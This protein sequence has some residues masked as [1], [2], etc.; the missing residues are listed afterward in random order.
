[1]ATTWLDMSA[2]YGSTPDVVHALRSHK[3]GRLLTQEAQERGTSGKSSYLPCNH[4]NVS[5]CTWPGVDTL[6]L[7]AGGDPRTNEDWVML[8]YDDEQPYQTVRM[9]MRAKH[10]VIVNSYQMAYWTDEM[11]R[12][13]DDGL[14][15]HRQMFDEDALEISQPPPTY[16]HSS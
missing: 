12:P 15:L 16:G 14:P 6:D 7:F 9:V 8:E 5:T 13:N 1:M 11:P 2:L 10:M 4:M 3:G